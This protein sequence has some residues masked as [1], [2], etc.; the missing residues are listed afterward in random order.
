MADLHTLKSQQSLGFPS[1]ALVRGIRW[2]PTN[3]IKRLAKKCANCAA[4][5]RC[6]RTTANYAGGAI[7]K[8]AVHILK[9]NTLFAIKKGGGDVR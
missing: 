1:H 7:E 5:T 8:G 2:P 4:I 9:Q 6:R 3:P